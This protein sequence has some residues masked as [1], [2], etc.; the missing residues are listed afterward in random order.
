MPGGVALQ[1]LPFDIE[2]KKFIVENDE[3]G[4]PKPFPSEIVTNDHETG[5]A[6]SATVKVNEPA[7]HRGV[8]I[9]IRHWCRPFRVG[10]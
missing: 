5:A 1:D 3:T 2:L 4:M 9:S 8:A 6:T 7:F 10:G